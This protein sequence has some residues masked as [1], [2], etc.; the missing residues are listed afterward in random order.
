MS[1]LAAPEFACS[2]LIGVEQFKPWLLVFQGFFGF[3]LPYVATFLRR[4]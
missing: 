3:L 1:V 4:R 2:Y